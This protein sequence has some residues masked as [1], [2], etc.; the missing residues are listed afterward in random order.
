[1]A[2]G[3]SDKSEPRWVS[4]LGFEFREIASA[5]AWRFSGV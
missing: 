3:C 4:I 1:M 2:R 5:V